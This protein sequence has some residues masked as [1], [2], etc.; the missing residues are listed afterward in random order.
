LALSKISSTG[1]EAQPYQVREKNDISKI[2]N[3]IYIKNF[4]SNWTENNIKEIF[5]R[6]GNIISVGLG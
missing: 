6:Y 5:S 1:L 2:Y 4:N 3:N